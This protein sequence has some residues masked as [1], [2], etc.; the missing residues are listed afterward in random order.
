MSYSVHPHLNTLTAL[1][2]A[3]GLRHVVVCPGSRNAPLAHN[4]AVC[5]GLCC[6][7]M[8]DERSAGF[9]ALGLA[10][11]TSGPVAV[12]VTSG[13]ALLNVA[14]A[15]AEAAYQHLPLVVISAD[16]PQ[17]WI[18]QLDEQTLP[19]GD[20]F[21]R[22]VAKAVTLPEWQDDGSE[23]AATR[24]WH[25]NRLVNEA[26]IAA[27]QYG[28]R[29]VHINVPITP[30][31]YDFPVAELPRERRIT[32]LAPWTGQPTDGAAA[33]ARPLLEALA[34]A[35]RPLI[36][37]GQSRSVP[38]ALVAGLR[39]R[40]YVVLQ[41]PLSG[42]EGGGGMEEMLHLVDDD[43]SHL[44][45]FILY[46]DGTLVSKTLKNY[47]RRAAG[48]ACWRVD[49]DGE[50]HD[51]FQNLQGIVQARP[52]DVLGSIGGE[53]PKPWARY[54]STLR[55]QALRHRDTFRPAFSSMLA[56]SLFERQLALADPGAAVHYANSMAVRL[57]CIYATHYIYCNRGVNG[58]EGSLST[59]A[60]FSL[61][62]DRRVYCIIGDLSF[63]YDQNALWNQA[64]RGNLRILLL[65]N[66]GG[67]I[68]R[69][70]DRLRQS[71]AAEPLVMAAHTTSARGIC[72]E[73]DIEY[74]CVHDAAGLPDGLAALTATHA[75]RPVLL[76]VMTDGDTDWQVYQQYFKSL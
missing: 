32:L 9:Y 51:T 8:T 68:F 13:T 10:Q 72:E 15:V 4:F 35:Q 41:E 75:S 43:S 21:G 5:P 62:T 3:H 29:P 66:G 11:A 20:A 19:Q 22:F 53:G 16:R 18:D 39:A 25:A 64:L 23:E 61:A 50:V 44:P 46:V 47:L 54:W 49:E 73:N 63:F 30:P 14:P 42:A 56:V 6:H 28:E 60:G 37:I 27:R 57:G 31:L 76:E 45:D 48:A 55:Q 7:P 2:L 40:H 38:A 71:P 69:K 65:N 12:C 33:W 34:G 74:H 67:G 24:H 58:I 70:F 59:A 17:A 26:L 1:L 52:A 36:V